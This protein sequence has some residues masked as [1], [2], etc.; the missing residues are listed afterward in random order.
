MKLRLLVVAAS[1][2]L[3]LVPRTASAEG[4]DGQP[5]SAI[6]GRVLMQQRANESAQATTDMSLGDTWHGTDTGAQGAQ[7]VS[8]GG[9]AAGQSQAGGRH[10]Q[11]CGS[12]AQCKIYFG[13]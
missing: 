4:V 13:Q 5:G 11:S 12:A 2:V 6:S 7:N 3:L 8:Y 10:G 9:V 1:A